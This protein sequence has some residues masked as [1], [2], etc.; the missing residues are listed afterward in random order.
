MTDRRRPGYRTL[1]AVTVGLAV[2][3]SLG[4]VPVTVA[5]GPTL[6]VGRVAGVLPVDEPWSSAWDQATP[7]DVPLA[8]QVT[9]VPR[10]LRPDVAAV[11]ARG[12]H[13]GTR[14]ALLLEWADR[15]LDDSVLGTDRFA[16]GA[17]IQFAMGSG[18]SVCM[19]QQAGAL[20]IWHW[21]ADWAADLEGRRDL[22][23]AHPN[24]PR[25]AEIPVDHEVEGLGP[26]GFV[27]ARAVGN[28]RSAAVVRSSVE[29]LNAAG[30]GTLTSQAPEGQNVMGASEHRVWIWRVVMSR[31]L[32][33][34]DPDDLDMGAGDGTAV[35]ALAVWDGSKGDRNGQ[36]SV[37]GWLALA[38]VDGAPGAP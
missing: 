4:G 16:D 10:L 11:R 18:T 24:M 20:N 14:I 2:A 17:A 6:F 36:K 19:G 30:F 13:D 29:D 12:L 32:S 9:A 34:G 35:I 28:P 38:L 5:Q 21:K 31:L 22:E 1:G 33:D 7:L 23:D 3:L 8:G 37:S 25:D 27:T 26:D 15:T